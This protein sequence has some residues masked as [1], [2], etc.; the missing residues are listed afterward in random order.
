MLA[1][2]TF[3]AGATVTGVT[4]GAHGTVVNN[5]DGTVTYTPDADYNGTDSF[6]YTANTTGGIAETATVTVTVGAVQDAF[7]DTLTTN[8]DTAGTVN[9]LGERHFGAGETVTASPGRARQRDQQ[10]RHADLHAGRAITSE[11]TPSPIRRS[12]RPASPR[13]RPST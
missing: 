12:A 13:P 11:P 8:E 5:G 7:N 10:Q 4:N 2:D 9:V 6:T 1:N 3:G